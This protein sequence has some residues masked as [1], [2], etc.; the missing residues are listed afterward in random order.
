MDKFFLKEMGER[1]KVYAEKH[2][3]YTELADELLKFV[4]RV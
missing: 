3:N 1:G 2:L 4:E